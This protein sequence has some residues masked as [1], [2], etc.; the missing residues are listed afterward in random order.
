MKY[1]KLNYELQKAVN[2][3][4][5]PPVQE[6][7]L[8]VD[9]Y[10]FQINHPADTPYNPSVTGLAFHESDAFVRVI[11]GPYGSGKSTTCCAEIIMRACAMPPCNDGIRKA[12]WAIV[13]NTYGDLEATSLKTWLDWASHLGVIYKRLAPRMAYSHSFWDEKGKV[14]IE[15]MFIALDRPDHI[16]KLKSLELTGV[17]LNEVSE[18]PQAA[19]IHF[20]GRVN[21]FPALKDCSG[22][23]WSGIIADTNPPSTDS[24]FYTFFEKKNPLDHKIFKQPPGL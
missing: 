18:I 12:R 8:T 23:Y 2:H 4:R 21:R 10:S 6:P 24:W 20:K 5:N 3:M 15:L 19:L 9:G 17:F 22:D 16:R 7:H 14:E 13:R 11:M 1:A